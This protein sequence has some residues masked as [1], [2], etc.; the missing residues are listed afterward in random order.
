MRE[1]S[2]EDIITAAGINTLLCGG[3]FNPIIP[4]SA[5]NRLAE[6]LVKLFNVDVLYPVSQDDSIKSFKEKYS[7]LENPEYYAREIF[8]IDYQT[9]KQKIAYLDIANLIQY[10]W[11]RDL[12]HKSKRYKTD[13]ALVTWAAD[14]PLKN[15][16]S[17]CFGYFPTTYNLQD[18]FRNAFLNGL[19]AK[20]IEIAPAEP[21]SK[22]L[23]KTIYPLKLTSAEL[24]IYGGSFER[25]GI[26][27]GDE[28]DFRDLYSFW[29]LRAAGLS[30]AFLPQNHT[31][32]CEEYI[33]EYLRVFD[34][35][36]NR[37]PEIEENIFVHYQR[38][39]GN[40]VQVDQEI[41]EIANRF[42]SK[43][44]F[45][46]SSETEAKWNGL[47]IK[48]VTYHFGLD[49]T[50]VDVEEFYEKY[51]VILNLQ[52]KP[53][54]IKN[55]SHDIEGQSVIVSLHPYVEGSD[56]PN[57]TLRPPFIQTLSNVYSSDIA[58]FSL[59]LRSEP[60]GVGLI[61][62]ADEKHSTL[63]PLPHQVLIKHVLEY[64]GIESSVSQ[65]GL[66]TARILEKLKSHTAIGGAVFMIRGVRELF[67]SLKSDECIEIGEATKTIWAD[68]Q[69]KKY[70][71]K[72]KNSNQVFDS[73][74]A[75]EFFRAGLELQCG[76]CR[77][78]NWLSLKDMDD[79]WTCTYC[80]K[81]HQT[82]LHLQNHGS[83][84]FR[85]SGLFAKDNNQEGAIPVI[86][87]L[88]KFADT[89]DWS[90]LVY[91][92]SLNLKFNSLKCETDLCAM[93]YQRGHSIELGIGE[94]KSRGGKIVRDDIENLKAVRARFSGTEITC[95]LVF[96]KTADQFDPEEVELFKGLAAENIPCVL[97][98]NR[99]LESERYDDYRDDVPKKYPLTFKD[100]SIN[101]YHR[102]L[103]AQ[104]PSA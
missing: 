22:N 51:R 32:R 2:V 13:C 83:W 8:H 21:V 94:C 40:V 103:K 19:H 75:R 35:K 27:I 33:K 20:L 23:I 91:T 10:Y 104:I 93:Q 55:A 65:A 50:L 71:K 6:Q 43:K 68:G 25:D 73:L 101:S 38:K 85:K 82:S 34:E 87:T 64:V 74:L 4:M 52:E 72:W 53:P 61:I 70:Q 28:N 78:R 80:G 42:K 69:F 89:F 1:G 31:E 15:L 18:D 67:E 97:F 5:K 46:F 7:Y 12:K 59:Q 29:N 44:N 17:V 63:Y 37:S 76:H 9:N 3:M 54:V 88:R 48:A 49:S 81:I 56:Y 99:E 102:Y 58:T 60:E 39:N 92:P 57:H 11:D 30:I 77:L 14:D 79:S 90:N 62:R 47:N 100:L 26:Y 95:F 96:S 98:L 66:I 45:I 16:F 86:L 36:P 41:V 84:K 24:D